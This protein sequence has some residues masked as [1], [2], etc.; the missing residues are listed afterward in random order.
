MTEYDAREHV[1][2]RHRPLA[3][4]FIEGPPVDDTEPEFEDDYH[5][6]FTSPVDI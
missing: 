5:E 6:A 3:P 4:V 1:H 2:P